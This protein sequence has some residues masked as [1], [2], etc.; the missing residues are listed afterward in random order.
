MRF[1]DLI[2][3]TLHSLT[4]NKVRSG[5]TILGIVVGI[6][7]VIAM[8]SI[9][10]GSQAS[11]EASIQSAGSNL[12]TVSPSAAGASGPGARMGASSIES[13]TREDAE[14]L[15]SLDLISGV[16]PNSQG[17][18]Q[19][20][21][22]ETN[23][24]AQILGVTPDYQTVKGLVVA[25]GSFISDRDDTANAQVVVLGATIAEDLFGEDVDPIG[26]HIRS[27]NMLLTVIGV[28]EEKGTSGFTN[29]DSAVLIPLSTCSRYVTGSEYLSTITL[30][31]ADED[32]M[33]MAENSVESLLLQRHGIADADYADFSILNM[34]DLM[35]TVST[36]TGTFT[37]L[38]AGIAA[39][40]LLVGGIGIMN[41]MLTTVTERTR[42]IGLRKAIGADASAISAQFLAESVTLTLIG[43]ALGIVAGWGMGALA[44]S[45]LGITA[46][47]TLNS[48]LLAAGVCALIGVV[49]GYYPARRAAALSPIEALRYQ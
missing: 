47:I 6:A 46:I 10:Q 19:L 4:S 9:G 43:G 29:V 49:F 8:V 45:L 7:S 12:L 31:V 44:G 38:L 23:A 36:V 39:I 48:V 15:E 41:M 25:S 5:L 28:L 16:A 42:E 3:E 27:G 11:I 17:Q 18:A 40:S 22:G 13:L 2:T 20:V 26:D 1:G 34:A 24:N 37:T 30:T 35:E 33:T 32:Q 21:A 14:A